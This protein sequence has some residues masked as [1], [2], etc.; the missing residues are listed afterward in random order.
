MRCVVCTEHHM[1]NHKDSAM[2]A[3]NIIS[4][5]VPDNVMCA[6]NIICRIRRRCDVCTEHHAWNHTMM[7]WVHRT[8]PVE[9]ESPFYVMWGGEHVPSRV[10]SI[11][12]A[13]L[14]NT[15]IAKCKFPVWVMK[16][17]HV[18]TFTSNWP[19]AITSFCNNSRRFQKSVV[20]RGFSKNPFRDGLVWSVDQN[21]LA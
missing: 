2:C 15:K 5:I 16:C 3:Q 4:G 10:F 12:A 17:T 8:S 11:T 20:L 14:Y 13:C 7:W 21:S 18:R 6:Q 9:S 1:W 19:S